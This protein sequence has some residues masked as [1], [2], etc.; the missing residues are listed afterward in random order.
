F[1]ATT[2]KKRYYTE[3]KEDALDM[4]KLLENE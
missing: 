3:T 1:Q 2:I 4:I